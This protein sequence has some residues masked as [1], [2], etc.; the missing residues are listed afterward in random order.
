MK[1]GLLDGR[2]VTATV[3]R[4]K[5]HELEDSHPKWRLVGACVFSRL[6]DAVGS[7]A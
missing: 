6:G 1:A 4:Q 5:R 7:A 3:H 2:F